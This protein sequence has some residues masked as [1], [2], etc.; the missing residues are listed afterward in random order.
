MRTLGAV[1]IAS[2]LAGQALAQDVTEPKSGVR[3]AATS[4]GM[5]L[6]GAGLRTRTMLKVKV[7]AVGLYVADEALRGGLASFKG[8]TTG[9]DFYDQLIWGDFG[10]Q[11]TLKFLRDVTRDQIQGAFRDSLGKANPGH[12]QTFLSF[13]GDTKVGEEYVI[14]W[15]PGS[16]LGTTVAGS[17]RAVINDKDF[18][19]AVLAVW[20]G[21]KPIQDD[22]KRDLV[23]R[24]PSLMP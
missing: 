2:L 15:T 20:L 3:F 12:V 24:A 16:G 13:F 18:A 14:R 4:D 21:A 23:G 7:Y 19:A 17:P 8:R 22:I 6:L 11:V 5:S 1:V 9:P 10:K